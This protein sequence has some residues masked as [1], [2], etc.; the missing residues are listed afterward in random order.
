MAD[1]Y[2]YDSDF[3]SDPTFASV[4][5]KRKKQSKKVTKKNS[6]E[7]KD[8]NVLVHEGYATAELEALNKQ[9]KS[10]RKCDFTILC[11]DK[12]FDYDYFHSEYVERKLK[13]PNVKNCFLFFDGS[14]L[15]QYHR[16][17]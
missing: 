8:R 7:V 14:H 3:T 16:K 6:N 2:E 5:G 15:G 17:V 11:Q 1:E 9:R 10:G 13:F 12:R 4:K